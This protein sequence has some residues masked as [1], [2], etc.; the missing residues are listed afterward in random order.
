MFDDV[1]HFH[2]YLH[3][4]YAIPTYKYKIL[5]YRNATINVSL[6]KPHRYGRVSS[7]HATT[8][9]PQNTKWL[10]HRI[11]NSGFT[12]QSGILRKYLLPSTNG[13]SIELF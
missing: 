4:Y 12:K 3:C 5:N 2:T 10:Y 7:L 8:L 11:L 1:C 6:S 9:I 13:H